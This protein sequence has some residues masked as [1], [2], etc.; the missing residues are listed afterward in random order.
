MVAMAKTWGAL[1]AGLLMLHAA[2]AVDA[3]TPM[4][5]CVQRGRVTYSQTLCPGGKELGGPGKKRVTVRYQTPPQDRATA[6]RRAPLPQEARSE[7]KALDARMPRQE[8]Q[9]KAMGTAATPHDEL[10]LVSSR[11]RFR[12]LGC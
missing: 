4:Y 11:K 3:Q 5:K 6:M 2:D 1:L 12:E 8:A 10:P 9:L 7:C